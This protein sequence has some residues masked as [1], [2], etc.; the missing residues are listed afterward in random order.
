[1]SLIMMGV[2]DF[3]PEYVY[4]DWKYGDSASDDDSSSVIVL[5]IR[6]SFG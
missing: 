3:I 4:D 1:M 2:A 5:K 6:Q